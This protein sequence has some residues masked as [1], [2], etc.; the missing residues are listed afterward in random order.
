[1][2]EVAAKTEIYRK[3]RAAAGH[4][5]EAQVTCM[6][7]THLAEDA[8]QVLDRVRA[9]LTEYLSAHLKLFTKFAASQDVGVRPDEVS[10]ADRAALIEHG[11]QRYVQTAGLFGDVE[12]CRPMVTRLAEAGVTEL[13]CLIDFGLLPEQVLDCVDQLGVLQQRLREDARAQ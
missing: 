4:P 1:M 3:A 12:T 6:L 5:A 7:H 8:G 9:P 13:G 11:L 10:E 2:D